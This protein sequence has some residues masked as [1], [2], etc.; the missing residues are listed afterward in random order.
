MRKIALLCLLFA[1]R[2]ALAQELFCIP[3]HEGLPNMGS[4][5]PTIDGYVGRIEGVALANEFEQGWVRS[6]LFTYGGGGTNA[7]M[8]MRGIKHN[9]DDL[10]FLS[11]VIQKDL[12]F[13]ANDAIS[14]VLDPD[15]VP[16]AT[17]FSSKA[18]RIDIKPVQAGAGALPDTS[19]IPPTGDVGPQK[20]R[21]GR[22][23][24]SVNWKKFA[25]GTGTT[26]GVWDDFPLNSIVGNAEVRVRSWEVMATD[27]G[28]S[29]EIQLPTTTAKAGT[30]DWPNL[31][32][33]VGFYANALNF[34]N[35][36]GCLSSQ[37]AGSTIA[38]FKSYQF[39][40]PR[41]TYLG[42]GAT[43]D[44]YLTG[45]P[46][47]NLNSALNKIKAEWLGQARIG[48]APAD[49][50]GLR[51]DNGP[52]GIGVR[53]NSGALGATIEAQGSP[54]NSLAARLV[55]DA[56]APAGKI[57]AEFRIAN[58]G[59][60]GSYATWAAIAPSPANLP[61]GP[62]PLNHGLSNTNP[63]TRI[64]VPAGGPSD[65]WMQM[66]VPPNVYCDPD[67]RTC[68]SGSL[69][70][71]SCIWVLLDSTQN[72]YISEASVRRN[73]DIVGTS[74]V[75]RVAEI[76][77]AGW[78][79][80]AGPKGTQEFFLSTQR[81]FLL[82]PGRV[83]SI[84]EVRK[85]KG[86][87]A[88]ALRKPDKKN[89]VELFTPLEAE[90]VNSSKLGAQPLWN[91]AWMVNATR[92]TTDTLTIGS[93]TYRIHEPAGTFGLVGQHLGNVDR[94]V[95][96]LIPTSSLK[97]VNA[98]T[99]T[100]RASIPDGKAIRFNAVIGAL[101]RGEKDPREKKY[102]PIEKGPGR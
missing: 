47:G 28:W 62:P 21:T 9:S 94:F 76:N 98:T 2:V 59:I 1:C 93:T 97:A 3:Q 74:G 75:R 73:F 36:S 22:T 16:G 27:L 83:G 85:P 11:F 33:T 17:S 20:I 52:Y 88:T 31:G 102:P 44:R 12:A 72:A 79:K 18:R 29:V 55:N 78:G 70:A 56:P 34:C 6:G 38:T 100:Y 7:W 25:P 32:S 54:I 51:F 89:P 60:S 53:D 37:T 39:T 77:A 49:C 5:P 42:G 71:H 66:Q 82:H 50:R 13:N 80:P 48:A 92:A 67:T 61:A 30:A 23:P 57:A 58:W 40:W 90:I 41:T 81:R 91:F 95:D 4:S 68:P 63:T 19:T 64:D 84:E 14:I 45:G 8:E 101:E 96:G 24:V 15:W 69:N 99:G 26:P 35:S 46:Y 10:L 65:I 86:V 43:T 87:V